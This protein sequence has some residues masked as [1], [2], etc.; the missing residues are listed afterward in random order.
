MADGDFV[1]LAFAREVPDP[2]DATKK[3]TTTWFDM[4]RIENGKIAEHW[5]PDTKQ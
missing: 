3:Y 1:V 4:F 5:D 2:K